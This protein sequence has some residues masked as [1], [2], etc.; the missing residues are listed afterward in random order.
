MNVADKAKTTDGRGD[1]LTQRTVRGDTMEMF[2]VFSTKKINFLHHL[3]KSF[4][5]LAV[6]RKKLLFCH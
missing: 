4:S 3:K 2:S 6:K 5:R 1:R